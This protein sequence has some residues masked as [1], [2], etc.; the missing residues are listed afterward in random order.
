MAQP[1][2]TDGEDVAAQ[3]VHHG[4]HDARSGQDHL[5][6]VG[7]EADDRAAAVGIGRAV[8]RDLAVNFVAR[9]A[10]AVDPVR[11]VRRHGQRHRGH[12]RQRAAHADEGIRPIAPGERF[13][14]RRDR[15]P[16]LR[17]RL[18]RDRPGQ[19]ELLGVPD[20][21]DVEAE[22]IRYPAVGSE[23]ELAAPA[24]GVEDDDHA[25]LGNPRRRP[26]VRETALL[27]ARQ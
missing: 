15:R 12:V 21:A 8:Q 13:E 6:A 24:P 19:A 7:L 1:T 5:G 23:A 18:F 22:P 3:M 16:G 14:V 26:D 17:H 25:R 27:V 4:A 20:G 9:Q 10:R 2:V 11:V